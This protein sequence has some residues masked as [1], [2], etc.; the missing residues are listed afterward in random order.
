[1]EIQINCRRL[2][3]TT[4]LKGDKRRQVSLNGWDTAET[5]LGGMKVEWYSGTDRPTDPPTDEKRASLVN[6]KWRCGL[7]E[8]RTC[9]TTLTKVYSGTFG[10]SLVNALR[11]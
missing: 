6:A 7:K 3:G 5:R 4:L 11:I 9:L 8:W 10:L 2:L 1:M